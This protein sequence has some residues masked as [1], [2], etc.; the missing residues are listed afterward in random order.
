M[1]Q[2]TSIFRGSRQSGETAE[3]LRGA[4]AA[5]DGK[6]WS[7]AAGLYKEYLEIKPDH[8]AI[9]V[10]L[11][12]ALKEDKNIGLALEAYQRALTLK[13]DDF[14]I[15]LNLGHA[16]KVGG[17][18][19]SAYQAY[20]EALRLN[21]ACA[22]ARREIGHLL[23]TGLAGPMGAEADA[24]VRTIYLE[25]ADIIEYAKHNTTLS[26]IQRVVANLILQAPQYE[27]ANKIRIVPVLPGFD[28]VFPEYDLSKLDVEQLKFK[29]VDR[30]VVASF[31]NLMQSGRKTRD[32]IAEA[33]RAVYATRRAVEPQS[34]DDFAISGSFW[35]YPNYDAVR[36]MRANG[37]RF[38]LFIHDLIQITHPQYVERAANE[39][40]RLALVDAMMLADSVLTNSEYVADDVRRYLS[41]RMNFSVPVKAV[42]L[43]TEL[44]HPSQSTQPL[45][46]DVQSATSAPFVLSVGTIEVRKNH[47]YMIRVWEILIAKR[48]PNIPHLVFVGKLGWDIE[49]FM[50]YIAELRSSWRPI[51]HFDRHLGSGADVSLR[52]I[53]VHHV[54]K[55]HGGLWPAG[56][57]EF[58]SR[59][60][61]Y[62]VEPIVPAGSRGKV[63]QVCESRRCRG[64]RPP[65][66]GASGR[67]GDNCEFRE[68][69]TRAVPAAD[70]GRVRHRLLQQHCRAEER[71]SLF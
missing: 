54:S 62:C 48:V 50:K 67:P 66:G 45:R 55:L 43:A 11:G 51:T 56:R 52:E 30:A 44:V 4:D 5:R 34:G 64:R 7:K 71:A 42:P 37:V 40:F 16:Y 39:R 19:A 53:S 36:N 18:F 6:D 31:I 28:P 65:S 60:A 1:V 35:I 24:S 21:P 22:D 29:A 2:L 58:G 15:H 3:L 17:D 23:S 25:I 12:H 14:D 59:K 33:V 41:S 47:M 26:G 8:C 70:M 38:V 27:A 32:E 61:L 69:D 10:Q 46:R 20:R 63:C 9:W 68:R 49:P 57:G 13:P